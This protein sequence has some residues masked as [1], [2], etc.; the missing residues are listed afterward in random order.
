MSEVW[1]RKVPKQVTG[2]AKCMI[3]DVLLTEYVENCRTVKNDTPQWKSFPTESYK[4][5]MQHN[6]WRPLHSFPVCYSPFFVFVL[7]QA[8]QMSS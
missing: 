8:R 7:A 3:I 6:A 4:C 1:F 2:Q 5:E